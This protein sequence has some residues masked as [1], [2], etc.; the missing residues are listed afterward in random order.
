MAPLYLK[1]AL[2]PT[3]HAHGPCFLFLH[4]TPAQEPGESL[5]HLTG[6]PE[7]RAAGKGRE[8]ALDN[9]LCAFS[10]TTP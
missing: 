4:S 5:H 8:T 6:F 10:D 7:A 2:G 1:V 3:D 9:S